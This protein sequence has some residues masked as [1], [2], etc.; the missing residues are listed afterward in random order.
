MEQTFGKY[1]LIEK[2][3]SGGMAEVYLATQLGD[4]AGF[5]KQ[6]ALKMMSQ[7]LSDR[8]DLV[9]MF[10]DEARIAAQL[11]HPNIVHVYDLGRVEDT[12]YIAMEYVEGK[13]LRRICEKGIDCDNFLSREFAARIIADAAAGLHYAHTSTDNQ[14]QPRNVVHR[15]VTPQNILVSM[16]GQIKVADFGVAKAEDRLGHT[17][18]GQRKGK[19]S[20][21]SPEQFEA[22]TVDARSDVYALGILLYE[23]TV[24]T[25]LF[26]GR[27][28]FET[29]SLIANSAVTPPRDLRPDYPA[30]LASIVM[31]ALE[32]DPDDRY[33]SALEF[34]NALEDWLHAQAKR[35]G[36][37]EIAE[38]M[39]AIFPDSAETSASDASA[40]DGGDGQTASAQRSVS[41]PAP[42]PATKI[43]EPQ[44]DQIAASSD[45][46]A[47]P[48]SHDQAGAAPH[49]VPKPANASASRSPQAPGGSPSNRPP[50][51]ATA[52]APAASPDAIESAS[53]AKIDK[54][55][56]RA[57]GG[58]E[59]DSIGVQSFSNRRSQWMVVLGV[60]VAAGIIGAAVYS[61]TKSEAN[62]DTKRSQKIKEARALA[63]QQVDEPTPPPTFV[64][65][66][67]QTK[68]AGAHV[69][70]NGLAADSKTPAKFKLVA[71]AKNE[72][73]FYHPQY[74]PKRIR[75]TGEAGAQRE[76]TT[77][78]EFAEKPATAT[79]EIQSD[80]AGG[81]VYVDGERIGGAPQVIEGITA[82]YEH[83]VE[84]RKTDHWAF[85]GIFEV[86][87]DQ[88][89]AFRV[90]LAAKDSKSHQ[91]SVDVTYDIIPKYSEIRVNGELRGTSRLQVSEP[92]NQLLN[93]ELSR[94]HRVPRERSILMHDI[95]TFTM[96]TFLD[97]TQRNEGTLKISTRPRESVVYV[98]SGSHRDNPFRLKLPEDSYDVVVETPDGARYNT[99][100]EV[101]G[102]TLNAYKIEV[103][104]G[105]LT[106]ESI[107]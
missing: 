107:D 16:D 14:G 46:A 32:K 24:Q 21:M 82:G 72:V 86:V 36:P 3:G 80:P 96:R 6:V 54:D 45:S 106:I 77:L 57:D 17:R 93:V 5:E 39:R 18:V 2:I 49:R 65:V 41:L 48:E 92:R 95:G 104:Q 69:V 58:W 99:Q 90:S 70:V 31:R 81:I 105:D 29:M 97:A 20:Y 28:D 40:V 38:Y 9:I 84:V 8:E 64:D 71:D 66:S 34:Q 102:D 83:H 4:L 12:L 22:S 78:A 35:V 42:E 60:L 30:E 10:L 88:R 27:S 101:V 76:A 7:N 62:I 19:L 56:L 43:L 98:N 59:D 15:D 37:A 13:D 61:M 85:A 51:A 11:N 74:P 73:V 79:L 23:T 89:N 26:R 75:I 52:P 103:A 44:P 67:L 47:G 33:Q 68:P 1:R 63:A 100:V 94:E 55:M 87:P 91:N 50:R 25:R 53:G